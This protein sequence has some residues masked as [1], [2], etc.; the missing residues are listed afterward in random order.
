MF[1]EQDQDTL[2]SLVELNVEGYFSGRKN[3]NLDKFIQALMRNS[4]E[5]FHD[6]RS[7]KSRRFFNEPRPH[8][9]IVIPMA[10]CLRPYNEDKEPA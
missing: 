4:P 3:V 5:K 8:K 7:L 9:D 6:A 1:A 2:K 10:G